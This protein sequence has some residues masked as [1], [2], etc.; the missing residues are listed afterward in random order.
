MKK[1]V[2]IQNRM[3]LTV[4]VGIVSLLTTHLGLEVYFTHNTYSEV[5]E[6]MNKWAGGLSK[7]LTEE[8][9]QVLLTEGMGENESDFEAGS[10]RAVLIDLDQN[11]VWQSSLISRIPAFLDENDIYNRE[12]G[13]FVGDP[14]DSKNMHVYKTPI[15]IGNGEE[16][17]GSDALYH[18]IVYESGLVVDAKVIAFRHAI[19]L[20]LLAS[21]ILILFAQAITARWTIRP[22]KVLMGDIEKMKSGSGNKLKE[23]YPKE[24]I[25]ITEGLSDLLKFQAKQT[26]NY[27]NSLGNLAHSLKT[28]LAVIRSNLNGGEQTDKMKEEIEKSLKQMDSIISYQLSVA[29]KSGR[30]MFAKPIN[31]EEVAIEIV[32]SLE[33]IHADKRA[34][35]EFEIEEDLYWQANKGDMQELLGNLL[36]NA[37]KWCEQRVLLS[38]NKTE[39][40]L[41]IW[42]E[43]DGG[44]IS[45]DKKHD[46]M[47]RGV[48]ADERVHGHGIGLAIVSEIV[49]S[50]SGSVLVEKSEEFGGAKFIVKLPK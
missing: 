9:G 12:N 17:E 20:S 13:F 47:K 3:L 41:E 8:N 40:G 2:S 24:L 4:V 48:R 19:W 39:E 30:E 33:K 36:E 45:D 22:L 27:Q 7:R 25:G 16:A 32:S 34:L 37:F 46:I 10:F 44:G 29:S 35:C 43:D 11:I 21:I 23:S 5:A 1:E 28:P 31:M 42:V 38:M 14:N 50:Y 6:R 18:L 49:E 26:S 15:M